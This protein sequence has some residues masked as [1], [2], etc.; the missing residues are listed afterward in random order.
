MQAPVVALQGRTAV[1]VSFEKPSQ[2]NGRIVGYRVVLASG[3]EVL[4][5]LNVPEGNF[6][7]AMSAP[8]LKAF[9]EYSLAIR[10]CTAVGCTDSPQSDFMT[11]ETGVVSSSVLHAR[12]C[13]CHGACVWP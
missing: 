13:I 12:T 8:V 11:L 10:V 7:I 1:S 6:S 9:T 2:P 3:S 4:E 5:V